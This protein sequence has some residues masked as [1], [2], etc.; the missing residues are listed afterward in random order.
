M[1][2]ALC[3]LTLV[4]VTY[5]PVNA[6]NRYDIRNKEMILQDF[7]AAVNRMFGRPTNFEE[8]AAICP[9]VRDGVTTYFIAS[10]NACMQEFERH[11]DLS[12]AIAVDCLKRSCRELVDK[13][14]RELFRKERHLTEKNE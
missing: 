6:M 11:A 8:I 1:F 9:K 2:V 13:E 5:E 14:D 7:S 12:K 4:I 3:L 10:F